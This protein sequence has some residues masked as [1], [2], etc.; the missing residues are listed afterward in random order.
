MGLISGGVGVFIFS[1]ALV[2]HRTIRRRLR[3]L[4]LVA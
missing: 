1:V 4:Q 3:Q 2:A